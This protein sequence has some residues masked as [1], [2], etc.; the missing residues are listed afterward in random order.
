MDSKP[1]FTYCLTKTAAFEDYPF[2]PKVIV[3]KV[4]GKIFAFLTAK[5]GTAFLSVKCDPNYAELLRQIYSSIT[6]G[7]HLNK[8]HWN[9][10]KLDGS[11]PGSEIQGFIDHSYDLVRKSLTRKE[12]ARLNQ[13]DQKRQQKPE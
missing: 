9:T 2:G 1:F 10:V 5:E 6:P 4:C 12:Q 8:R 11:I 7:Y 13:L 3:I